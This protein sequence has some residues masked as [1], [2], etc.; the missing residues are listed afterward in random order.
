MPDREVISACSL[1]GVS[2][3]FYLIEP[4][5]MVVGDLHTNKTSPRDH[6][7][8]EKEKLNAWIMNVLSK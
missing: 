7:R 2:F 1:T 5:L 8:G 4:S 3:R 6:L